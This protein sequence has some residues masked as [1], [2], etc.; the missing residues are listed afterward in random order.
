M[1]NLDRAVIRSKTGPRRRGVARSER[2]PITLPASPF[3]VLSQTNT[4][5]TTRHDHKDGMMN[6]IRTCKGVQGGGG[7]GG[8]AME[9]CL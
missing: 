2:T 9:C 3:R 1:G 4:G 7:C 8:R 6:A 5:T